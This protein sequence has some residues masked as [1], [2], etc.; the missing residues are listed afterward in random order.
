[1]VKERGEAHGHGS[2]TRG[3]DLPP[4]HVPR[5]SG[6]GLSAGR[7]CQVCITCPFSTLSESEN[8]VLQE[9]LA[10]CSTSTW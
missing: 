3:P 9:N 2:S 5:T 6:G 4:R 10:E 7:W 8:V 1:M